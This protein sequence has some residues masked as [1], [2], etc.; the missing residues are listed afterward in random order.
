MLEAHQR[1]L[2]LIGTPFRPQG[3]DPATGI[4]CIGL[5]VCAF[6]ISERRA[7]DYRLTDGCWEELERGLRPWFDRL[8]DT[9]PASG[10]VV[11]FRLRRSFH[12]GVISGPD[13]IHADAAVGRV[14]A[15]RMSPTIGNY[16]RIYR[17]RGDE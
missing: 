9:G 14:V 11:V 10:D 6:A 16:C 15:R 13:L 4:D 2:G 1:A 17:F 3:R 12:F 5:V 7:P 8:E